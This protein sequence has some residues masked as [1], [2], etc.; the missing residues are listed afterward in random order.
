MAVPRKMEVILWSLLKQKKSFLIFFCLVVLVISMAWLVLKAVVPHFFAINQNRLVNHSLNESAESA[1]FIASP[2]FDISPASAQ[3]SQGPA[4]TPLPSPT[5]VLSVPTQ[6]MLKGGRQVFQTYNNCGPA[7]LSMALSYYGID[8]SQQTLGQSLRPWQNAYGDNDDKSVTLQELAEKSQEYGLVAYFRPAGNIAVIEQLVALDLPVLTRTWL[9]AGEDIGHFRVIVG[10]DQQKQQ[11]WQD[12][13]FQGDD[14]VYS[15]A[16]FL[17]LWQAFNYEFLVLVPA[18]KQAAVEAILQAGALQDENQAWEKAL[19]GAGQEAVLAAQAK[20]SHRQVFAQFNQITALYH[21]Q[22]YQEAVAQYQEIAAQL[23]S[24]M[25]WYQLEPILA[26][27]QLGEYE[28]VLQITQYILTNGNEAYA[29]LYELQG[30]IYQK[31][32]E[33]AM[34]KAAFTKAQH[35][36]SSDYWRVNIQ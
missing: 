27:Y 19:A 30:Q 26:Y 8:V 31:Q 5:L 24:R 4:S 32:Q 23:P 22:R 34:A 3:L 1:S 18:Q 12:D 2:Q 35:Y 13:S 14:R 16:D 36:N 11:L 15:Y 21:L 28:S 9:H 29:E 10:Y 6:Y 25:L 20:D 33:T 17:N 7:S